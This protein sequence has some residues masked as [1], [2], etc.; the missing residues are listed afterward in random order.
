MAVAAHRRSTTHP[1][2][3]DAEQ[4]GRS[5]GSPDGHWLAYASDESGKW[6][7][8]QSFPVANRKEIISVGGGIEPRWRRDGREL[9]YLGTDR[10]LTTVT[11]SSEGG[12]F[13]GTKAT[14]LFRA[15][16][17]SLNVFINWYSPTPDGQRF[18]INTTA[19]TGTVQPITVLVN[20][21]ARL[22]P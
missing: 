13:K 1:L 3:R 8:I 7:C 19:G 10:M 2:P 4:R 15:P 18:I 11:V 17:P 5:A 20:W 16:V 22:N 12:V 21:N 6:E 14:P 9:F